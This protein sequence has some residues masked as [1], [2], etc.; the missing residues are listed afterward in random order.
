MI[1][2]NHPMD[3]TKTQIGLYGNRK[4]KPYFSAYKSDG[5]FFIKLADKFIEIPKT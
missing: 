5:K 4:G 2:G 1:D 3:P